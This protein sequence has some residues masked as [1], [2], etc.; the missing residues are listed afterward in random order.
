MAQPIKANATTQS[1]LPPTQQTPPAQDPK[2]K[3]IYNRNRQDPTRCALEGCNATIPLAMRDIECRCREVFCSRH[4]PAE[5][6]NCHFN[7]KEHAKEQ[8]KKNQSLK[9]SQDTN[10]GGGNQFAH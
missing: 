2:I 7:Y 6:H 4:K 5:K 8:L 10:P 3:K 9:T 1:T